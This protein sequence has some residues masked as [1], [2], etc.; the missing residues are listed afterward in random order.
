MKW[1][2]TLATAILSITNTD[3]PSNTKAITNKQI[4]SLKVLLNF[5]TSSYCIIGLDTWDCAACSKSL[6][7]KDITLVGD[8]LMNSFGYVGF[9]AKLNQIV[10]A[11]RGTKN[12]NNWIQDIKLSA[13][14]CPFPH[15]PA[16]ARVHL[17]FLQSWLYLR[18]EVVEALKRLSK[19]FSD[20]PIL[21]TGHSLGGAISTLAAIDLRY[22][23]GFQF[24][25]WRVLTI[26]QPRVGNFEFA[27][28]FYD[29]NI[30]MFRIVNQNDLCP[31]LPT[32]Y[33]GFHH[34]GNEIFIANAEGD[35][36]YCFPDIGSYESS[37][38]AAKERFLFLEKHNYAWNVTISDKACIIPVE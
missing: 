18:D 28:W 27:Q 11:F 12:L 6:R 37:N 15:A 3:Y 33:M 29:S 16:N 32:N 26:G 25:K 23:Y 2:I 1:I 24:R 7:V 14:D 8:H 38:C 4:E 36:F 13:P 30:V 5:A 35:A 9:S 21:I 19:K 17:G 34:V 10:L 20:V 22:N 31:H